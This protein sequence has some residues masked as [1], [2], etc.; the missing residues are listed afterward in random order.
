MSTKRISMRKLREI[1][2][3]RL[4]GELSMRQIRD[5]L[6]LSLGAVQKV[7]SKA[8][9]LE[10][11]WEAIEQRDDKELALQFY[12]KA[13]PHVSKKLQLPDWRDVHQELKR[14]GVTKHLLW[15][16]Y[17][18]QY[19]NRSYS[20][21]QYCFL[22]QDWLKKQKRPALTEIQNQLTILDSVVFA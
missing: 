18:Q 11:N 20:Y 14:K 4:H 6:R 13:D 3:L 22:Y 15:E 10:L 7:L 19:P 1:L 12:P 21:P 17:T 5:A 2:K 9:E 8:E 16:E